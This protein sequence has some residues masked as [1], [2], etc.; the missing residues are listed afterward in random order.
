MSRN[1]NSRKFD[2]TGFHEREANKPKVTAR[3]LTRPLDKAVVDRAMNEYYRKSKAQ[4]KEMVERQNR[5][6]DLSGADK[7][8]LVSMLLENEF[9]KRVFD[10]YD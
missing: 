3:V 6:V 8:L 7:H 10:L 9:G 4:L 5:V 1:L 2:L